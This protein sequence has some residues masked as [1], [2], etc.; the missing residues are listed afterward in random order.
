MLTLTMRVAAPD[1]EVPADIDL[2]RSQVTASTLPDDRVE[3]IHVQAATDGCIDIVLF[4]S[5]ADLAVA[6]VN[7][8]ALSSRLLRDRLPGWHLQ[9]VWLEPTV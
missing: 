4:I 5:S 1:P 8:T 6:Q 2:I 3:H 7:A 9:K